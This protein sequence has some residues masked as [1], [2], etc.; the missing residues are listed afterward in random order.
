V[1]LS[2]AVC[3]GSSTFLQNGSNGRGGGGKQ[4]RGEQENREHV[5]RCVD[6]RRRVCGEGRRR[7]EGKNGYGDKPFVSHVCLC[8]YTDIHTIPGI[9]SDR[10]NGTT[11]RYTHTHT[12]TPSPLIHS[13]P[14][15]RPSLMVVVLAYPH[16]D[17]QTQTLCGDGGVGAYTHT[18]TH[19]GPTRE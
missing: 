16:I 8:E 14:K 17:T 6:G 4:A 12:R 9:I 10:H 19:T 2:L 7:G 1:S 11:Y 5:L 18:H 3:L 13:P 15:S